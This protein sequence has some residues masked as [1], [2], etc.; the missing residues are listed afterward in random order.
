MKKCKCGKSVE[1]RIYAQ[2]NS[3]WKARDPRY[4]ES[5]RQYLR[6]MTKLALQHD[7]II[8]EPLEI[9]ELTYNPNYGPKLFWDCKDSCYVLVLP[10][11]LIVRP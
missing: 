1:A 3:C 11:G 9:E 7:L 10:D 2:C 6:E 4:R 8:A 5:V